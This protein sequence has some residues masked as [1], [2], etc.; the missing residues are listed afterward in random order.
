[1]NVVID[2]ADAPAVLGDGYRVDARIVLLERASVLALPPGALVRAGS[3]WAAYVAAEGRAALRRLRIGAMSDAAIEVLDGL[4]A[5]DE[6]I[7]FPSDRV[8]DGARVRA[9]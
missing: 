9:R 7:V 2:V 1:M 3:E 5:G 6:V 8:R 4:Q